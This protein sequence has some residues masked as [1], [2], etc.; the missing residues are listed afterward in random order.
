M[1]WFGDSD[2]HSR[3]GT[4]AY[5]YSTILVG[6]PGREVSIDHFRDHAGMA[7]TL[8]QYLVRRHRLHLANWRV[9]SSH[10]PHL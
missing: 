3:D 5:A 9:N 1:H 6:I 7:H 10:F 2:M 8:L 4:S